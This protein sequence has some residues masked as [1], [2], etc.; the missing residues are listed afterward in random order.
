[1]SHPDDQ[2][3]NVGEHAGRPSRLLGRPFARDKLPMPPQ[4]RVRRHQ[5]GHL[6]QDLPSQA[7]TIR[8]QPTP[9][10]IGELDPLLAQLA[11]KD[12]V[13]LHQIRDR[14]SLLTIQPAG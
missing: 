1:M 5:R 14:L 2:K 10:G 13:L 8:G 9:L 4:N 6:A 12:A 3:A 7:V 11:S